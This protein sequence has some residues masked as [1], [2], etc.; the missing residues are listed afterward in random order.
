MDLVLLPHMALSNGCPC[1]RPTLPSI[2][3]Q[4]GGESTNWTAAVYIKYLRTRI[5]LL[6]PFVVRGCMASVGVDPTS[7]TTIIDSCVGI[8]LFPFF[9]DELKRKHTHMRSAVNRPLNLG[10]AFY[11]FTR[12]NGTPR[13]STHPMVPV[14]RLPWIHGRSSELRGDLPGKDG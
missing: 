14:T 5:Y 4:A 10:T 11:C 1:P 3:R 8:Y 9:P 7:T 2:E 12:F 13:A 6:L